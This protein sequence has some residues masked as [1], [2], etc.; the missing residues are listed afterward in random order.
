[1]VI[2]NFRSNFN[3]EFGSESKAKLYES[4]SNKITYP[5]IELVTFL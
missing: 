4:V 3:L 5:G 1:M 2:N